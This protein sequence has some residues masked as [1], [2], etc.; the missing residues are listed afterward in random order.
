M[1]FLSVKEAVFIVKKFH[2]ISTYSLDFIKVLGCCRKPKTPK[3]VEL[4]K[5]GNGMKPV[6]QKLENAKSCGQN[7]R[8]CRKESPD[9]G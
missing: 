2:L 8:S 5:I 3:N 9:P 6:R 1:L 4:K 7:S